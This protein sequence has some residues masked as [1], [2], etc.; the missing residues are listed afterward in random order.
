MRSEHA[1]AVKKQQASH[2][3]ENSQREDRH[4]A[5][6]LAAHQEL[7]AKCDE[8]NAAHELTRV[9]LERF[10]SEL[11]TAFESARASWKIEI[12]GLKITIQTLETTLL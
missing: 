7:K 9:T 10:A 4:K 5:E 1:E 2:E 11:T 6:R 8:M 12:D 3:S